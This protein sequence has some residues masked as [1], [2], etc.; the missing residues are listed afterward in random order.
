[1]VKKLK[2]WASIRFLHRMFLT[3][4]KLLT[5]VYILMKGILLNLMKYKEKAY[6]LVYSNMHAKLKSCVNENSKKRSYF[7][8]N[9]VF[10]TPVNRFGDDIM[11]VYVC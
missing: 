6:S 10:T 5:H 4:M 9:K 11:C 2:T 1:M 3:L 8:L 7:R